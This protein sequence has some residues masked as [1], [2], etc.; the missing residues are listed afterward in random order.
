MLFVDVVSRDRSIGRSAA[1]VGAV[2]AV[3]G[4]A[5]GGIAGPAVAAPVDLTVNVTSDRGSYAS[6]QP[7]VYTVRVDNRT[8]QAAAGGATVVLDV[9]NMAG[10]TSA[11]E[12]S[13]SAVATG[14]GAASPSG[15][16]RSADG[17]SVTATLPTLPPGG[18]VSYA[19]TAPGNPANAVRGSLTVT[20]S[21]IPGVGDTDVSAATDTSTVGVVIV[22]KP[23]DYATSIAGYPTT[24][25]ADGAT[26]TADV[27]VV[28][29]GVGNNLTDALSL[30]GTLGTGAWIIGAT[31]VS[32]PGPEPT[33]TPGTTASVAMP[34][35]P[36]GSTNVIRLTIAAGATC[37]VDGSPRAMTLT[38]TVTAVSSSNGGVAE[39]AAQ[40]GDNTAVATVS[41]VTPVCLESDVSVT[42]LTKTAPAGAIDHDG[43]F[44][45]EAVYTNTGP[46]TAPSE[47]SFSLNWN[48]GNGAPS[49]DADPVCVASG[50]AVCPTSWTIAQ[51]VNPGTPGIPGSRGSSSVSAVGV[52][53]SVPAGGTLTIVYSGTGGA[54]DN[55]ICGDSEGTVGTA[56]RAGSAFFDSD[57]LNNDESQF[58]WERV[59]IGC[60]INHDLQLEV[61]RYLNDPNATPLPSGTQD[62]APGDTVYFDITAANV[63]NPDQGG[64]GVAG[65]APYVD[66]NGY[67]VITR[68]GFIAPANFISG[69]QQFD[70]S[71][72]GNVF[73]QSD[74]GQLPVGAEVSNLPPMLSDNPLDIS[75]LSSAPVVCPDLVTRRGDLFPGFHP[76]T[77]NM[78]IEWS[79]PEQ[80]VLPAGESLRLLAAFNVPDLPQQYQEA[81][82]VPRGVLINGS[83]T[84]TSVTIS[85]SL[86]VFSE[87]TT[88]LSGDLSPSNDRYG[89]QSVRVNYTR[90]TQ[91]LAI[92]Q[93][94]VDD[95]GAPI[96]SPT[97]PADRAV[98]YA[99]TITNPVGSAD[100]A[101]PRFTQTFSPR[102]ESATATC[103]PALATG[104][105]I[106]PA[107]TFTAGTRVLADG[108]TAPVA[109]GDPQLDI[110]WGATGQPTLP[111][112][113]SVTFYVEA[114]YPAST[115][116]AAT[117]VASAFDAAP[118][119]PFP[120]VS[121]SDTVAPTASSAILSVRKSVT[122]IDPAPG[123]TVSFVVDLLNAG[124][125]A[126]SAVF[127]DSLNPALLAANPDG[128]ANVTCAPVTESMNLLDG[129]L[130]TTPCPTIA[131]DATGLSA[132]IASFAANSGLRITYTAVAPAMPISVPNV[133]NLGADP[134]AATSADRSAWVNF[135]IR[136]PA[137]VTPTGPDPLADTGADLES[138]IAL[139][140]A[141]L[142]IGTLLLGAGALWRRRRRPR[143]A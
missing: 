142:G 88:K 46:D 105:A 57:Q 65:T 4:L 25:V 132:S 138:G 20:A 121:D 5:L 108:S 120:L 70:L 94:I 96:A 6:D 95:S 47:V 131:S 125:A 21:V 71:D 90:C 45:F 50:G 56:I 13:V 9:P 14:G 15:F 37:N 62:V 28:N 7:A 83:P 143:S 139:A 98:R 111:A 74:T 8:D 60:G 53:A 18:W 93:T 99:V 40:N 117:A 72:P 58:V 29:S 68:F 66:F 84:A 137:V 127:S 128:F 86:Q 48:T 106:C 87:Q 12:T 11:W 112:G 136:E 41:V 102:V 64:L 109:S 79:D 123:E 113:S 101:L 104:G 130:G 19:L 34:G 38:S 134:D 30:G 76:Y 91:Q 78:D 31:L 77:F 33:V 133:A 16:T 17:R 39:P 43:P 85:T 69:N 115:S 122:P 82:C 22:S 3:V 140:A 36:A 26:F 80:T 89:G 124:D 61:D 100:L 75:C 135:L 59:G 63:S 2:L 73:W 49:L 10:S 52:G 119:S 67:S 116:S 27:S 110:T 32:G 107:G 114:R 42:S 97:L 141:T 81:G 24:A 51:N 23:A 126:S 1:L 44:E 92:A 55:L 103:D 118:G 35:M 54:V 129:V